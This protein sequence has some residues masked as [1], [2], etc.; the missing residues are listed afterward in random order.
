MVKLKNN[1]YFIKA[2][3]P[4]AVEKVTKTKKGK[5]DEGEK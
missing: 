2:E 3:E 5:K 1:Y 4:K